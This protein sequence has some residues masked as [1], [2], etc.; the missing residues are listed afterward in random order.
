[1]LVLVVI[2]HVQQKVKR[3]EREESKKGYTVFFP[4]VDQLAQVINV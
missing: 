3:G 1:M 2:M 4:L